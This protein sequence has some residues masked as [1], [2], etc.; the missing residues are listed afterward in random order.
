MVRIETTKFGLQLE[1]VY[2]YPASE[3][4]AIILRTGG[5]MTIRKYGEI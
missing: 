1:L 3:A 2:I 4:L 5:D